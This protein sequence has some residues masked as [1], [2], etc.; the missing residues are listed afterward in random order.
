MLVALL[1]V[2]IGLLFFVSPLAV[3]A[4]SSFVGV[5]AL[6]VRRPLV[7]LAFL[8]VYLPFETIV[9]KFTPDDIYVYARYFSEILIYLLAAVVIWRLVS[10]ASRARSTPID[11]PFILFLVIL[12]AS[13]L[14]NAVEPSIAILGT[15][16]IIRFILIF[17]I[18]V[19]LRP[20]R[21]YVKRLTAVMLVIVGAESLVGLTQSF[22]GGPLDALLL[23]SDARTFGEITL[24]SGVTQFW[25]PGSRIFAT[26]GRYDRLGNFLYFFLLIAVGLF[27]EAR[28]LKDRRD[29]I[30]LFLLGI[31]ALILTYS[32]ASWFAFLLGF[33]FIGILIKR[34]RRVTSAFVTFVIVVT[35]YLGVTGLNVR[36]ITEAPGQTLVERFYEAFSYARWR[37]EYYGLG[38]VFWMVQ[39]PMTV[40]PAAPLFGFGPGQ[41]GGGAVAALGN[42]HAYDRLGLPFGVFGTEGIIDNNWFS[43]WGESG[44]LGFIFFIWMY[45]ALLRECLRL[46]RASSDG[47]TKAL[48]IGTMAAM[49]GIAMNAFLSTIFEIRTLAFYLWMYA[50]FVVVLGEKEK[51]RG[52]GRL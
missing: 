4:I 31:P 2:L 33:L 5:M 44:T 45:L 22:V 36:F 38:R 32:R 14:I 9:L 12:L 21:A 28:A 18:V 49:L 27:Y 16:Q 37:G 40:I 19:Y 47:F 43:L 24:T 7:T 52:P 17:F 23:P 13:A 3:L 50:G 8:A 39:V 48:A 42:T 11:L 51:G 1:T 15:R 41:F 10:G 6:T 30:P 34:D 35:A 26:F 29:L 20:D 25:D 46:Y